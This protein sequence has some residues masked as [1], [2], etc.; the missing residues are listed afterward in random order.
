MYKDLKVSD[1][2]AYKQKTVSHR[3]G[4]LGPKHRVLRRRIYGTHT[5]TYT[6]THTH[7]HICIHT[8]DM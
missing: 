8:P 1:Q 7:T 2:K 5:Y 4:G 3:K 6:P